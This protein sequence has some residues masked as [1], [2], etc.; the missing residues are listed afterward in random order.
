MANWM[1]F[2]D[3]EHGF[4][5]VLRLKMTVHSQL[6]V[7]RFISDPG[8]CFVVYTD[9]E[10]GEDLAFRIKI[11]LKSNEPETVHKFFNSRILGTQT[12]WLGRF[13]PDGE[14]SDWGTHTQLSH[15][16]VSDEESP[17][18]GNTR[19]ETWEALRQG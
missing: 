12:V 14:I 17:W 15:T 3:Y 11:G 4:I 5:N 16:W 18:V 19:P 8:G 1:T 10:S 13:D 9:S 7:D 2:F 6:V